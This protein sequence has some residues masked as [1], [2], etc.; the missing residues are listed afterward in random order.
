LL[1]DLY[2]HLPVY[3]SEEESVAADKR[4]CEDLKEK[5]YTVWDGTR[6]MSESFTARSREAS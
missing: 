2:A 4:L 1:P 5:G 3:G 6:G